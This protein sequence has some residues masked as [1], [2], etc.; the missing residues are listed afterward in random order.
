MKPT[1]T[2]LTD[3]WNK[4]EGQKKS[5]RNSTVLSNFERRV[6]ENLY[7]ITGVGSKKT[8]QE[9]FH[10]CEEAYAID[11]VNS[12]YP[13]YYLSKLDIVYC[14]VVLFDL[15]TG[16]ATFRIGDTYYPSLEEH[17]KISGKEEGKTYVF[18]VPA[19]GLW[20]ASKEYYQTT[21]T[22]I[23]TVNEREWYFTP[24][25][26]LIKRWQTIGL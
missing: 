19:F 3:L 22:I 10:D 17:I 15:V 13:D 8:I 5:E 6:C 7:K 20:T 14:E 9:I 25:E 18:D 11:V 21:P 16:K 24:L 1:F 26:K 4:V 2:N 23:N 12:N